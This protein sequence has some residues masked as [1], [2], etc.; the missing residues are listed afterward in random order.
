[1]LEA[2]CCGPF[3]LELIDV[4]ALDGILK[5]VPAKPF[6]QRWRGAILVALTP[7]FAGE[8]AVAR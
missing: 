6:G 8:T 2:L 4:Q 7:A 1:M 5:T 3:A